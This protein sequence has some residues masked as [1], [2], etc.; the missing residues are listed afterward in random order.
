MGDHLTFVGSRPSPLR[1][2][3]GACLCA[4]SETVVRFPRSPNLALP[5]IAILLPACDRPARADASGNQGECTPG[6]LACKNER[7]LEFCTSQ[8]QWTQHP[9][10]YAC[11]REQCVGTC[12]PHTQPCSGRDRMICSDQ[13]IPESIE[14]CEFFAECRETVHPDVS[15]CASRLDI[16]ASVDHAPIALPTLRSHL[17]RGSPLPD[18]P[19]EAAFAR[20]R[21]LVAAFGEREL[22][23]VDSAR[24][25]AAP[26]P[27]KESSQT[28]AWATVAT[29]WVGQR[30][31]VAWAPSSEVIAAVTHHGSAE[32]PVSRIHLYSIRTQQE[33]KTVRVDGMF[34]HNMAFLDETTMAIAD[35]PP[36]RGLTTLKL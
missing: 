13:G 15:V 22:V 28:C 34:V 35:S 18:A 10:Q 29:F 11:F 30:K 36:T 7:T 33:F 20:K 27:T 26:D 32:S 17:E 23:I 25:L 14:R 2:R 9:C 16:L 31:A 19:R 4:Q 12:V 8:G 6:T 3:A 24:C 5:A 1:C 21:N